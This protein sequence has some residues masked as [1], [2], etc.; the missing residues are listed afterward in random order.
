MSV[1]HITA[2]FVIGIKQ[3][4]RLVIGSSITHEPFPLITNRHRSDTEGGHSHCP[5]AQ[6]KKLVKVTR[7]TTLWG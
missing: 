5:S 2:K 1:T 3:L 7:T 4:F 6:L